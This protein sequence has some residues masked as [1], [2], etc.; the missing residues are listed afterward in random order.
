[1]SDLDET[2]RNSFSRLSGPDVGDGSSV[3]E[4]L[5]ARRRRRRQRRAAVIAV[6]VLVLVGLIAT[7][8]GIPTGDG[9]W[10]DV[11]TG[12]D[13]QQ[14]DEGPGP[15]PAEA[16]VTDGR[17]P[18]P[19]ESDASAR[20]PPAECQ[21]LYGQQPW[22]VLFQE[23]PPV[24]CVV[25]AEHQDIEVFN[26]GYDLT[27]VEWVD[28]R[29]TLTPDTSF[30]TGPIGDVLSPGAHDIQGSPYQLPTI[31]VLSADNSSAATQP[32]TDV[33]IG[34]TLDEAQRAYGLD[35]AI[36]PNLMPG[37]ECWTAVVPGDP[38][39]PFFIVQ[40]S[41]TEQ[42]VLV[43]IRSPDGQVSAP[44]GAHPCMGR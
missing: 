33:E 43:A 1:M 36:D 10:T 31:H 30:F 44:E 28:G 3:R 5:V 22:L 2:I 35:L 24:A 27:V 41:Q 42:A 32:T 15:S 26:K 20:V 29:R 25:V 21:A 39:S 37:P 9:V 17:H 34:M 7:V 18:G 13:R 6:P 23:S 38:Y 19:S 16:D 40:G 11:A 14:D 12:P 8:A 4:S